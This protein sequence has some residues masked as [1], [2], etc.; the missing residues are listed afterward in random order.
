MVD[1]ISIISTAT[2]SFL[3]AHDIIKFLLNLK[4][5]DPETRDKITALQT[6]LANAQTAQLTLLDEKASLIQSKNNLEKEI[7]HMETWSAET[8]RYILQ[9]VGSGAF[10]Y[11]LK[12]SEA[13][14][15]PPHWL[16]TTC[17]NKSQKSILVK[18]KIVSRE[19]EYCCHNN[20][21][22]VISVDWQSK[23]LYAL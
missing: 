12:E 16:C 14:S 13:H 19:R 4:K 1:P 10:A 18:G 5:I 17:Y 22:M 2:T 7:T 3:Q 15:E 23:P 6:L 21:S 20:C 9:D 11:V 8:K